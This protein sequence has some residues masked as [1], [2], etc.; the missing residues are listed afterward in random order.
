VQKLLAYFEGR[1]K[2]EKQTFLDDANEHGNTGLHW[3]ALG[4]HL[5][6]VKL[7]LEN[8]ATPALA[9]ERNYVP[10]DLAQF[11]D[12]AEVAQY[13]LSFAGM[14]EEE[15]QESGLSAAAEGVEIEDEG[16]D[17]GKKPEA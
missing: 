13:F 12:H 9:N 11:N 1:S 16:D 2:E 6:V 8:G 15:N 17:K 5:D 3:A 7:L 4:G 14:L 10:L